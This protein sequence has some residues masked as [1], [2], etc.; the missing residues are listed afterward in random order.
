[1]TFPILIGIHGLKRSGKDTTASFI[2]EWARVYLPDRVVVSRGF[3]DMVK[4]AFARQ[5]MPTVSMDVAIDWCDYWKLRD[6][7]FLSSPPTYDIGSEWPKSGPL[8]TPVPFRDA[9]AQFATEGARDLYGQGHWL[10]MLVPVD[11]WND[12]WDGAD[13]CLVTD[14]RFGNEVKR[15]REVGGI[16]W[17]INR[18]EAIQAV[19][20][21]ANRL[22]RPVHQSELG[23]PDG[24]FDEVIVNSGSL[25]MLRVTVSKEMRQLMKER[26]T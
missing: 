21:E 4:W 24:E 17:K 25:D 23:L 7:A 13:I 10:D 16:N 9:I 20:D 14:V 18:Q 26:R 11:D 8:T 12:R 15:I 5:F 6:D 3:A 2:T 19:Q 22:G 1:M